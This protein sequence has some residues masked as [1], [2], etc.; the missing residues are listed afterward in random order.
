MLLK[1]LLIVWK[2]FCQFQKQVPNIAIAY[3][4]TS[5]FLNRELMKSSRKFLAS[6][7]F[8][9]PCFHAPYFR[10]QSEIMY[11]PNSF[12]SMTW[13]SMDWPLQIHFSDYSVSI[14][15]RIY[16]IYITYII[17]CM[18]FAFY[19]LCTCILPSLA[20]FLCCLLPL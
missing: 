2:H 5:S 10:S 19:T 11:Q 7:Q 4:P 1:A 16:Q 17:F 15:I 20:L 13:F 18:F 6:W 9:P 14:G 8:C 12:G 3:F